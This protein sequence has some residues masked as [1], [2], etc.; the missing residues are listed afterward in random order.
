[1]GNQKFNFFLVPRR[2]NRGDLVG[3]MSV[4]GLLALGVYLLGAGLLGGSTFLISTSWFV[5]NGAVPKIEGLI[6]TGLLAP[7]VAHISKAVFR[8]AEAQ[9]NEPAPPV[10]PPTMGV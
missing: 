4:Y 5:F 9:G 2:E 7:L 10:P 8:P 3:S 6:V 1:M